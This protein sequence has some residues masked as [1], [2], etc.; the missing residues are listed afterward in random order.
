MK[1]NISLID[2]P[3]SGDTCVIKKQVSMILKYK[4]LTI[5]IQRMWNVKTEKM[6]VI[7][8]ATRTISK[9]FRKYLQNI[10]R[11]RDI[12]ELQKTALLGDVR[13]VRKVLMSNYRIFIMRNNITCSI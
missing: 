5:E 7:I 12:Q 10:P 4:Y 3:N 9:P 13:S 1:R 2:V 8:E 6:P 11:N